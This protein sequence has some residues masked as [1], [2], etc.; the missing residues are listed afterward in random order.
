LNDKYLAA[1]CVTAPEVVTPPSL[2][3]CDTASC[4]FT[5]GRTCL[6]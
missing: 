5:L 1:E 4:P 3:F 2:L 6:F